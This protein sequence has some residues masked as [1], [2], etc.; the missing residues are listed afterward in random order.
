MQM[1]NRFYR[2]LGLGIAFLI[3]LVVLAG[4]GGGGGQALQP[5]TAPPAPM[6]GASP[7]DIF[8]VNTPNYFYT[9]ASAPF[10]VNSQFAD[11]SYPVPVNYATESAGPAG[12]NLATESE[13]AIQL[14]NQADPRVAIVSGVP[15]NTEHVKVR[16]VKSISYQNMNNILGLTMLLSGGGNPYY[17]IQ[18]AAEDP[19]T[20]APLPAVD[21]EKTITH[22]LGHAFGLGHSPIN[23][24][25]MYYRSNEFQGQ[26]PRYFLTFGDAMAIWTTL[27]NRRINFTN[28]PAVTYPA[29]NFSAQG[30]RAIPEGPGTVVCVYTKDQ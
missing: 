2:G 6:L 18:V 4:C 26:I 27:N 14:W 25:L 1:R 15:N 11:G 21:L 12:F 20:H 19:I 7:T 23:F 10:P 5:F 30:T 22:E 17:D 13:H 16:L 29:Q 9:Y 3:L 8:H 28:R 24:D